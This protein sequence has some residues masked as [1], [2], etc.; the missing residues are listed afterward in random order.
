M[1]QRRFANAID[2]LVRSALLGAALGIGRKTFVVVCRGHDRPDPV[3]EA[4]RLDLRAFAANLAPA[5]G[6]R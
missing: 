4:A 6:P 2:G 1:P 5:A 3:R